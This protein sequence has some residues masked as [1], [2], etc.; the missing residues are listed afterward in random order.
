MNWARARGRTTAPAAATAA[1]P[2][3]VVLV[4]ALPGSGRGQQ[5]EETSSAS[6]A[7]SSAREPIEPTTA[8]KVAVVGAACAASTA[9][10]TAEGASVRPSACARYWDCASSTT[11]VTSARTVANASPR[12]ATPSS[13]TGTSRRSATEAWRAS[14]E[15]HTA[16]GL[17]GALDEDAD[18]ESPASEQPAAAPAAS[19]A[20]RQ[21]VR[22]RR[23]RGASTVRRAGGSPESDERAV[24]HPAEARPGRPRGSTLLG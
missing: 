6:A 17:D 19:R 3:V 22:R 15:E 11:W 18:D 4:M 16:A 14:T 7:T 1:P 23:M 20:R 8:V 9:V 24:S 12:A 2:P 13:R 21:A 10:C 5:V